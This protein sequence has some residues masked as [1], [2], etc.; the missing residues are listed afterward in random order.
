[1]SVEN[2]NQGSIRERLSPLLPAR[3]GLRKIRIL[4]FGLGVNEGIDLLRKRIG[5]FA[6]HV[7]AKKIDQRL[8]LRRAENEPGRSKRRSNIDNRLGGSRTTCESK[9]R[10]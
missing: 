8:P 1:M 9:W 10:R 6:D 5:N 3:R 2:P 4:I 7:A